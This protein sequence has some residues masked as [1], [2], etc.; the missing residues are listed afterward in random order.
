MVVELTASVPEPILAFMIVFLPFFLIMGIKWFADWLVSFIKVRQGYFSV[1]WVMKN[2]QWKERMLKP[3]G[4][5]VQI[6]NKPQPFINNPNFTAF[7]G[8]KKM[9][10][11]SRIGDRLRQLQIKGDT[12]RDMEKNRGIPPETEFNDMLDGA[13]MAGSIFGIKK[14]QFEKILLLIAVVAAGGAL[15]LGV[16]NLNMANQ[17]DIKLNQTMSSIPT[18]NAI[19]DTVI[20]R[21]SPF[22]SVAVPKNATII[23]G[24]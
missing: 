1:N 21:I 4:N 7:R 18:V 14:S 5:D 16:I 2:H 12:D 9:I 17:L 22:L 3:D 19:A 13:E 15:L 24:G 11:F 10:F 6:E 23:T 8:S 20:D